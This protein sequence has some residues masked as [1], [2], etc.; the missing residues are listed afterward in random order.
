MNDN[1]KSLRFQITF[2]PE[3]KKLLES[4]DSPSI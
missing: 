3:E 1:P 4:E 2:K